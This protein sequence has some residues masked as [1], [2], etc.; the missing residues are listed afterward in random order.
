MKAWSG[1]GAEREANR[2]HAMDSGQ[3]LGNACCL[4]QS[5]PITMW[6]LTFCR[7]AVLRQWLLS[8]LA[9]IFMCTFS[10]NLSPLSLNNGNELL[11][12]HPTIN[13]R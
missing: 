1:R 2:H 3:V 4:E 10:M 13:N 11:D 12:K 9:F 6:W 7:E 5:M 8:A